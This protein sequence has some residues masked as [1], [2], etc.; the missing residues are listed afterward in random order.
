MMSAL[1]GS[2]TAAGLLLL[3]DQL[4]KDVAV[5]RGTAL[6]VDT[7]GLVWVGLALAGV[8]VVLAVYRGAHTSLP[9]L[10]VG[11]ASVA[12]D[13]VLFLHPVFPWRFSGLGVSLGIVAFALGLGLLALR[14]VSSRLV[15]KENIP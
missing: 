15:P 11:G 10:I 7:P 9:F 3:G 5:G 2:A 12:L 1:P 14:L 13:Y 4:T 8:A 6:S